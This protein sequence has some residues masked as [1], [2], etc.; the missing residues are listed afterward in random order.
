[1]GGVPVNNKP[2]DARCQSRV[3]GLPFRIAEGEGGDCGREDKADGGREP[4]AVRGIADD[5]KEIEQEPEAERMVIGR[6]RTGAWLFVDEPGRD[7]GEDEESDDGP[8]EEVAPGRGL[9]G[10]NGRGHGPNPPN[11]RAGGEGLEGGVEDPREYR[12]EADDPKAVFGRL[13]P[14]P[15]HEAGDA[16][17]VEDGNCPNGGHGPG[18][19]EDFGAEAIGIGARAKRDVEIDVE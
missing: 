2:H 19:S 17:R 11:I 14:R 8:S 4:E 7:E 10:G 6:R 1:M 16:A 5:G 13:A 18:Q 3:G 15:E 12:G 9:P